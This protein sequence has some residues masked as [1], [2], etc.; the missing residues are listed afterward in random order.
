[1]IKYYFFLLQTCKN[2]TANVADNNFSTV[3]EYDYSLVFED[4]KEIAV[5]PVYHPGANG[6]RNRSYKEQLQDWKRI[7]AFMKAEG[8]VYE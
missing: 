1:M 7:T 4:G 6:R 8:V 5:F 3:M 2:P